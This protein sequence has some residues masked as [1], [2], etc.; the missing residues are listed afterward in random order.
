MKVRPEILHEV[1]LALES[2]EV[3][4]ERSAL[5]PSAKQTYLVHARHFVRWLNDDFDPGD[6]LRRADG[7]PR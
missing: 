4:V 3:E 6:H 7:P 2:Y 1:E 5:L